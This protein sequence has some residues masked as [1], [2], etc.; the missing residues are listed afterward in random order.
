MRGIPSSSVASCWALDMVGGRSGME[1]EV[2][3]RIF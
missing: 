1:A 3:V 2:N